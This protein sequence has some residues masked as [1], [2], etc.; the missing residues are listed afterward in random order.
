[1]R[2]AGRTTGALVREPIHQVLRPVGLALYLPWPT[3]PCPGPPASRLCV[4]PYRPRNDP[5]GEAAGQLMNRRDERV[6]GLIGGQGAHIRPI[7]LDFVQSDLAKLTDGGVPRPEVVKRQAD[8]R[9]GDTVGGPTTSTESSMDAR[10][11][12]SMTRGG[13]PAAVKTR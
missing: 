11:V 9:G 2:P 5:E 7:S 6:V 3:T 4:H 12:T 1:M 13:Y 8:T 10:S